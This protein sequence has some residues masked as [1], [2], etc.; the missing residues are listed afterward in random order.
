[1]FEN[2]TDDNVM[3]YA[4]KAYEK[5]SAIMSEFEE[6]YSRILYL[7]RLLTKY[8]TTG[9]LKDRLIINHIVLLYNVFGIEAATRLLFVKLEQKDYEVIKPF[10]IFLN[11][12]PKVVKGIN[13]RDINTDEIK[14]DQRAIECLRNLKK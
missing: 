2:L 11:F 3:L 4:A 13:G 7:K 10:L 6:D 5:P 9:V 12:L 1:M 14:L 8:H